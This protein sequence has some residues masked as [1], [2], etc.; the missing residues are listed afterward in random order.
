MITKVIEL[1]GS[2]HAIRPN[3]DIRKVATYYG[4]DADVSGNTIPGITDAKDAD[5]F[6]A[7]DT[8]RM[9]IF[10]EDNSQWWEQRVQ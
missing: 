9:F 3:G 4:M 8:M 1:D 7:K 10:D 5:R 2:E 6:Y